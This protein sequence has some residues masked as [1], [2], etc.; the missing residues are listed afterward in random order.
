MQLR[1]QAS[2]MHAWGKNE[3]TGA[4]TRQCEKRIAKGWAA[5][6]TA[7]GSLM[8]A[9]AVTAQVSLA[10]QT[11]LRSLVNSELAA[12]RTGTVPF[13]PVTVGPSTQQRQLALQKRGKME[14]R[15]EACV[16]LDA[17]LGN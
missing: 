4:V 6:A 12:P 5:A 15:D 16:A 17:L 3:T 9:M 13:A 8:G 14:A 7:V 11:K 2:P 10:G 1:P